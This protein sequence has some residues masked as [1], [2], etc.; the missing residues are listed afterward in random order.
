MDITDCF[1]G[2]LLAANENRFRLGLGEF[3]LGR[4]I[5]SLLKHLAR[6]NLHRDGRE[7]ISR[8]LESRIYK[9][10]RRSSSLGREA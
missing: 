8:V 6:E 1:I 5:T 3:V 2:E 4:I 9:V 7:I 10:N